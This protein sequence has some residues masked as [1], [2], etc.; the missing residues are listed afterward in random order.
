MTAEIDFTIVIPT[1]SRRDLLAELLERLEKLPGPGRE[2][3]VI[4]DASRDGTAQMLRERFPEVRVLRNDEPQGFDALPRAVTMAEGRF[5]LQLDDDAY[6]ATFTLE[7]LVEHFDGRGSR[8]G[9][10]AM[11]FV[12]PES[13]RIGYSTYSPPAG[14]REYVPARGFAAGGVAVRREAALEVPLSPRGYFM[15]ETEVPTVIEYLRHGWEADYLASAPIYHIW[16]ARAEVG[17]RAAYLGLRNDIVTIERYFTGWRRLEMLAG[18]YLAGFFHLL[19]ARRP[20]LLLA[21]H[22][23]ARGMLREHYHQRA[24]V[25]EEILE[26]VYPS[27]DGLTLMTFFGETNRRRVA[28]FL[29]LLPID[30]T[31]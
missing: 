17:T 5:I 15:Y 31:V 10:V 8:L 30:Q 18:R 26:R 3:I 12:E 13:G 7:K 4:D 1:H 16:E 22:R 28:W 23:E 20:L 9:L 21:A 25:P 14:Q 6:P 2:V 27:F 24:L 11:P 19:A 29:G